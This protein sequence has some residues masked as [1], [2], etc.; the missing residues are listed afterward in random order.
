MKTYIYIYSVDDYDRN[1]PDDVIIMEYKEH[2]RGGSVYRFTPELF[3]EYINDEHF[4]D[5]DW[6]ARAIKLPSRFV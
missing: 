1:V 2:P 6:W 3:C 5:I 4:S